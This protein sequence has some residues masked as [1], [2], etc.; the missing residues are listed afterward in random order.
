MWC[1]HFLFIK[2]ICL[3][4]IQVRFDGHFSQLI[5]PISLQN[6]I[7]LEDFTQLAFLFFGIE[8]ALLIDMNEGARRWHIKQTK[9]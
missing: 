5:C 7:L 3:T 2:T 8:D 4:I 6:N 1:G 9:V